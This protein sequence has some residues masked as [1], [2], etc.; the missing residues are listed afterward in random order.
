[1]FA[2]GDA[3]NHG[4]QVISDSWS[5]ADIRVVNLESPL[6]DSCIE[7]E[8]CTLYSPPWMV[9]KIKQ[10][11]IDVVSLANNHIHDRGQ[12]GIRDTIEVLKISDIGY[13]GAGMNIHQASEPYWIT[14]E[15]CMFGYCDFAKPYLCQV[16]VAN[17]ICAGIAP[18]RREFIIADLQEKVPVGKKAILYFHWGKEHVRLPPS[19]DITLVKELLAHDKVALIVGSHAHRIQGI[20][21]NKNKRAYMCIGNFLFP[22]FFISPPTRITYSEQAVNINKFYITRLYHSVY[23]LT[24]KKWKRVNRLSIVLEYDTSTNRVRHIPFLQDDNIPCVR[25]ITGR[26]R[27][28]IDA[29]IILFTM[30]YALPISCYNQMAKVN[31][32]IFYKYWSFAIVCFQLRQLANEKGIGFV[33][34]KVLSRLSRFVYH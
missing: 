30:V 3:Q 33:V 17:E 10:I 16:A 34:R 8:K 4:L 12:D 9:D 18:L 24:Y 23:A 11:E 1:M 20:V 5:N 15:L 29:I 25:E 21:K 13:F 22:N 19:E 2:G 14:D 26:K 31:S 6:T 27:S 28:L 32:F 7:V